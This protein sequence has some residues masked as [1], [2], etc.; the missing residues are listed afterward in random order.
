[1]K[2]TPLQQIKRER[3]KKIIEL[4]TGNPD[5]KEMNCSEIGT[6]FKISRQR[7]QQILEKYGVK[8]DSHRPSKHIAEAVAMYEN[9]VVIRDIEEVVGRACA[10]TIL[11]RTK[12][13]RGMGCH[14]KQEKPSAKILSMFELQNN[15]KTLDDIAKHFGSTSGAIGVSMV[16]SRKRW[17]KEAILKMIQDSKEPAQEVENGKLQSV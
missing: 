14:M 3:D 11:K 15:G 4:A 2:N 17:G 5:V 7:V 10:S 16:R 9:G 6:L 1:M 12:M 13:R 8:Y